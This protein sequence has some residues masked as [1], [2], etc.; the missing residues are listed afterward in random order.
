M[1]LCPSVSEGDSCPNISF[2]ITYVL[3]FILTIYLESTFNLI[4]S[5]F[6]FFCRKEMHLE[7]LKAFVGLHE[8]SDLNLVQALRFVSENSKNQAQHVTIILL[9]LVSVMMWKSSFLTWM[10]LTLCLCVCLFFFSLHLCHLAG[11]FYGAS[12]SRERLKR[13]TG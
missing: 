12:V 6:S 9:F 3:A 10:W 5:L 8:F 4:F 2:N 1:K 13:L 7:V 11:S